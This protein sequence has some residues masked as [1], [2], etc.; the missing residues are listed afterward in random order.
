MLTML[1][2]FSASVASPVADVSSALARAGLVLDA[3]DSAGVHTIVAHHKSG[4]FAA[5]A[6][7]GACCCGESAEDFWST[8][9]V[10]SAQCEQQQWWLCNNGLHSAPMGGGKCTPDRNVGQFTN[11]IRHPVDV[12]VSGYLYHR[13]CNEAAGKPIAS[14]VLFL[15]SEEAADEMRKLLGDTQP[16][17]ISYCELLRTNDAKAGIEAELVR[18]MDSEN[19][20]APMLKDFYSLEAAREAGTAEVRNVCLA[21][22]TPGVNDADA[23]WKN[24]TGELSCGGHV[25]AATEERTL[26]HHGTSADAAPQLDASRDELRSMA[27]LAILARFSDA[28]KQT[29]ERI[30]AVCPV[31]STATARLHLARTHGISTKAGAHDEHVHDAE[32]LYDTWA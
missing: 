29:M 30:A 22:V 3:S 1:S 9:S 26:A 13:D 2:L 20:L 11:F 12:V 4:T 7:L 21:S 31:E 24:I 8:W 10:C 16:N 23:Y 28:D 27:K 15:T 19:G 17:T 6:M 25:D 32:N 18:T 14:G 5:F